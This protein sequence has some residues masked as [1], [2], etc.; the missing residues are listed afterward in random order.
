MDH[1]YLLILCACKY[2]LSH[3][4]TE[5]YDPLPVNWDICQQCK[6]YNNNLKQLIERPRSKS[7]GYVE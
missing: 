5:V 6:K 1:N 3:M 4:K 2:C 7:A